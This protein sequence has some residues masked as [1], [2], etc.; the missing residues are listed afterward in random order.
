MMSALGPGNNNAKVSVAM[1]TYNHAAFIAQ[2][3]ESVLAQQTDFQVELVIGEDGSRDRT[4]EIVCAYKERYPERIRLLL[5]ERNQG[6]HLNF[7][8]TL[9]A[10]CGQYVALLEGDDY[11]TDSRKLQ[12]QV[13]YMDNHP[14]CSICFHNAYSFLETDVDKCSTMVP[15]EQKEKSTL[16]DLLKSDFLPTCTILF[17]RRQFPGLPVWVRDLSQGDWPLEVLLAQAGYIGYIGGTM[18]AHRIYGGGV[19][20]SLTQDQIL[21]DKIK[22]YEHID[23]HLHFRYRNVIRKILSQLYLSL[24]IDDERKGMISEAKTSVLRCIKCRWSLMALTSRRVLLLLWRLYAPRSYAAV[25][26]LKREL[27]PRRVRNE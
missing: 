5:P 6:M 24:A 19:W 8:G 27:R 4:R 11:W 25:R 1:I 23:C 9:D 20:S 13:D 22:F 2:A 21:R 16:E 15:P 17:R 26:F 3:I 12:K 7:A 18:A 10:C 14:D